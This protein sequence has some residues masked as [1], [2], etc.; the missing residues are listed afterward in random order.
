MCVSTR[1]CIVLRDK[2]IT[3]QS[4]KSIVGISCEAK[5]HLRKAPS[6]NKYVSDNDIAVDCLLFMCVR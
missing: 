6:Q 5:L 2:Y 3:S 4:T 1:C